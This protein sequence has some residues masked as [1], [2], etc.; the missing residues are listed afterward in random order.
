[1]RFPAGLI[2]VQQEA[3]TEAGT[4]IRPIDNGRDE[5]A[6]WING[7]SPWYPWTGAGYEVFP[8]GSFCMHHNV[9]SPAEGNIEWKVGSC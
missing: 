3:G 5:V 7:S 8:G 4:E 2:V 9:Q 6:R 1:M